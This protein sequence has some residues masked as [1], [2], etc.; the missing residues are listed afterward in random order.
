MFSTWMLY[1]A[2][3]IDVV[4]AVVI[5][6]ASL[7]AAATAAVLMARRAVSNSDKEDVRLHL[8]LWL[9]LAL[10]LELGADILRTAVGQCNFFSVKVDWRL[11]RVEV[12]GADQVF[13][14]R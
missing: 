7:R 9:S 5:G 2:G 10:E 3:A 1:L 4:A 14:F 11:H 12:V 13:M 6:V 8:G